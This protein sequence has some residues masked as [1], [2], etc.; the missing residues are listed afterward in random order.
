MRNNERIDSL[1]VAIKSA[2]RGF[3]P[4]I[5]TALP[6]IVQS[7]NLAKMTCE[8][9]PSIQV[10]VLN[11]TTQKWAFQ[12]LP[13]CV[14][15]PIQFPGGGG[16]SLTFPFAK[17]DEGLIVF[18]C[19][20][21]DAWWQSGGVQPQAELR[22]H[23]L[24]DGFL[25]PGFRSQPRVLNNINAT[26]VELRKDDG[27]ISFGATATGFK[28]T[29]TLEVEGNLLLGGKIVSPAGATY[30]GDLQ[31]AGKVTQGVG[32]ADQVTLGTHSH[33]AN[34]QPPTPGT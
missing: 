6:G 32:G 34:N 21:I 11:Q 20:C 8:V 23:D 5:W 31:I 25:I 33:P 7:V 15:V 10:K 26:G 17:G 2:L 9:Q 30:A 27:S 12:N 24:S 19:R 13:L 18:A 22:M 1:Q 3:E 14:D 16:F 4:Q 29:G 28:V